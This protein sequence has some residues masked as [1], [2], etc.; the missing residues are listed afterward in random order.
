MAST[1]MT[2]LVS[3]VPP[4]VT[5]VSSLPLSL[6]IVPHSAQIALP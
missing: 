1:A 5:T 3:G 4:P 6:V 2:G